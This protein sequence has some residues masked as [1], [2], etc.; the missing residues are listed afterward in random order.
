MKQNV[1]KASVFGVAA[2]FTLTAAQATPVTVNN[3]SFEA[4]SISPGGTIG[5]AAP[6][7]WTGFNVGGGGVL[8][9]GFDYG[10]SYANAEFTEPLAAP[11]DGNNYLWVNRWTGNGTQVAGVYQDVGALSANTTYTLTVAIGLRGDGGPNGGWSPGIISLLN[12]TDNTG[13]ILATGGGLPATPN[14]WQNYTASFTTGATVSGDLIV[15]L[16][17]LDGSHIQADFDNVRLDASP[18]PEPGTC[19]LLGGGLF[20]LLALRRN[21]ASAN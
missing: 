15:D 5:E 4:Q 19:A 1:L 16:S 13:A 7:S 17:V 10:I 6:T 18:V 21:K 9:N 8:G 11:A 14:S 3:F 20:S 2:M 12:G